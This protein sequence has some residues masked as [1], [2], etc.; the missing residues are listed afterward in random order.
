MF[1][2][3]EG[4]EGCGKTTQV[5]RLVDHLTALQVSVTHTLEPG[6]TRIG[7]NIRSILLNTDNK[8]MS[9]L[10]EV[11][12]YAADRAQHFMEV[13]RTCPFAGQMGCVRPIL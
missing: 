3:F 6:D 7:H 8:G 12:L 11:L 5:K 13:I 4:I 1:I 2:T 10:A 9:P